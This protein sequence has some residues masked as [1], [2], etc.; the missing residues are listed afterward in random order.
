MSKMGQK[1]AVYKA[2]M[3][4]YE[5][6]T[7][8]KWMDGQNGLKI[9]TDVARAAVKTMVHDSLVDWF[10]HNQI[11]CSD[12]F[13]LRMEEPGYLERY[14]KGL[15]SNWWRKDWRYTEVAKKSPILRNTMSMPDELDH[16]LVEEQCLQEWHAEVCECGAKHSSHPNIHSDS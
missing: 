9:L 1:E 15:T 13:M 6:N 7:T 8:V 10:E 4:A 5:D 14:V 11:A 12:N 3:E 2:T 16:D